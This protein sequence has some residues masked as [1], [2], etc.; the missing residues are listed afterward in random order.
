MQKKHK[1]KLANSSRILNRKKSFNNIEFPIV[2]IGA[3]AGGLEAF[4]E[5][6]RHIK[7]DS[8]MAFVLVSHL[9]PSHV[10]LLTEILQRVTKMP[11]IEVRD[12]MKVESNHVYVI[13]P[14]YEMA[15]FHGIFQLSILSESKG[16]R[17]PINLFFSSLAEDQKDKAI[18]IILSGTGTDGT[19]GIKAIYRAGGVSFVQDP[20]TAK[21]EGMP[22]SAVR[23]GFVTYILP[24]D[25]M[26]DQLTTY[27]KTICSKPIKRVP[28]ISN[29]TDSFNKIMLFLRSK[30]GNDFSQYKNKMISRRLETRMVVHNIENKD[31]YLRYLNDNPKEIQIL[32]KELFINVTNFFRDSKA[33]EV[34]NKNILPLLFKN[35]PQDYIFRVWVPG[36]STGEE[37]YSIAIS[38]REYMDTIKKDFK[39]QIYGTDIIEDVIVF[40]RAG[41]Y[42]A[43]I[44]VDVSPERLTRFFSKEQAGYR[45]KKDIREMVIFATQNVIKDPPVTKLD[46]LSCRNL[47]IYLV[48]ELQNRVISTFHYALKPEGM[49]FLGSS[50]NLGKFV[51]SF[52]IVNG[53]WKFFQ[54]KISNLSVMGVFPLTSVPIEVNQKLPE[55]EKTIKKIDFSQLVQKELL[56]SYVPPSVV[57]D[58]KG[59]IVYVFGETGKYLQPASGLASLNVIEMA[60]EGLQLDLRIA[61]RTAVTKKRSIVCKNLEVKTNGGVYIVDIIIK[62][63]TNKAIIEKLL[64]IS[65]KEVIV[66]KQNKLVKNSKDSKYLK[67]KFVEELE[68]ELAFTKD[69][70]KIHS[71]EQQNF[72]EELKSTNEEL[73]STNE[74]LQSTNE[75]LETSKEELQ[76]INEE[77]ISVNS[78][79]QSKIEQLF[80]IQNDMKNLLDS[81]NIGVIFLDTHFIIKRFTREATK[82]FCFVPSDVGRFLADIKSEF[83]VGDLMADF[84]A[85]LDFLVPREREVQ[86]FLG[87]YYLVRIMPYR[88]LEN[89]IDGLVIT[90]VD[91]SER[92]KAQ[93][94]MKQAREY[95]ENIVDMI[96]EP[97]IVL[98]SELKVVSA[99]K[100]FYNTFKTIASDTI[101]CYFF[102]IGNRQW[103]IPKLKELLEDVL[104]KEINFQDIE[105]EHEFIG[106]GRR[107]MRLDGRRIIEKTGKSI[108]ILLAME[109]ITDKTIK[110]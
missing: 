9:D 7:S 91:I 46:L 88:T 8:G 106:I 51:E 60:R 96:R 55:L 29:D 47:L 1:N 14:N 23:S 59:N 109:D 6:F 52:R 84:Q 5:F 43:N 16:P 64:I 89:V 40:A 21:Y 27:V 67:S 31:V 105:I 35:K 70:L 53:K 17:F 76:S 90:F 110:F 32:F 25:K 94:E 69:A 12:Q 72:N 61:L 108:L 95:S 101:G 57:C 30:T 26:P 68:K 71:D 49:L 62:P 10:S 79:L 3:S 20:A 77:L 45:V 81:T 11:V 24:V 98:N 86:T 104:A 33:F 15:I 73:Q 54:K 38:I 42:P 85:V 100:C 82:V 97:F 28:Y 66:G 92:K 39:V 44:A 22:N 2:G 36:C 41:L 83:E 58:E 75:E 65:F 13:P 102:K 63:V 50:E 80:L 48:S 74:E 56:L 4:E 34:L 19:L 37:V 99:S 87:N 107:K 103:E 78:E 93:L 18:G